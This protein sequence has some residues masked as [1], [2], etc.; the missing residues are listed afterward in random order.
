M[1]Y[2]KTKLIKTSI[3]TI[4][5]PHSET[6]LHCD[7]SSHSFGA[8]LMQKSKDLKFHPVFYRV[9]RFQRTT[10]RESKLHSFELEM[11]AIKY[12]VRRFRIY[13]H[14]IKFKIITDC[15]SSTLALQNKRYQS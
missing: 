10:E 12:A 11:L 1:N 9:K 3:L 6:E 13:L 14:G 2:L 5:D 4:Y 15:N 7:A 8:I